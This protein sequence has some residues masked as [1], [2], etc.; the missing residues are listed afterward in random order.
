MFG[1]LFFGHWTKNFGSWFSAEFFKTRGVTNV[2]PRFS[3]SASFNFKF[4]YVVWLIQNFDDKSIY[5]GKK[6]IY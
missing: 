1:F 4:M 3:F 6:I 5:I 2:A